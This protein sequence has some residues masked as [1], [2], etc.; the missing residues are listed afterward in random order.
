[1]LA[2]SSAEVTV[3]LPSDREMKFVRIFDYP[4]D[5]I[6]Q[7]WTKPQHIRQWWGCH[8]STITICDI[9]LRLGGKW[10]IVMQ[11]PDNS[12]HPFKGTYREIIPN[13][14]LVYSE[15]YDAPQIGSPEW[16][17]TITFDD[18][19]GKTK[20]THLILHASREAR[21]GHLKSGMEPGMVQTLRRLDEYVANIRRA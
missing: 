13:E 14:R 4:R 3:S 7:A 10:R 9:D 11:M 18:F 16:T 6:F 21:D 19:E 17:T 8:G 12:E 5:L 15:C 1:M 20:L 2:K